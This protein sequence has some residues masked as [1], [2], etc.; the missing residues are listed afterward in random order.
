MAGIP[1]YQWYP[2]NLFLSETIVDFILKCDTIILMLSF[3][4]KLMS[5]VSGIVL[6][7]V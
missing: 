6:Y 4:L 1:D 7:R 2:L 3:K 5:S